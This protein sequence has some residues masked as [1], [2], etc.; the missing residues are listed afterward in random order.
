MNIDKEI[1][2]FL[3]SE[4]RVFKERSEETPCQ[5]ESRNV[6][7]EKRVKSLEIKWKSLK[8]K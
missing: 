3:Q 2:E 8:E 7:E 6:R 4:R 5:E 1:E